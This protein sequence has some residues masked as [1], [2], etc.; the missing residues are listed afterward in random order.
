MST[1]FSLS[2]V[3]KWVYSGVPLGGNLSKRQEFKYPKNHWGNRDSKAC[4][5]WCK[6][7]PL[8]QKNDVFVQLV[9]QR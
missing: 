4:V 7:E 8:L 6:M 3:V 1:I 9:F 2:V 5:G